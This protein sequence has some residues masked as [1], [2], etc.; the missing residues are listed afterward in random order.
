[1][2]GPTSGR[3]ARSDGN[4]DASA[5]AGGAPPSRP[6]TTR[7]QRVAWAVVG[8]TLGLVVGIWMALML[9]G[10]LADEPAA[11]T[12]DLERDLADLQGDVDALSQALAKAE[13]QMGDGEGTLASMVQLVDDV[14][15]QLDELAANVDGVLDIMD[16]QGGELEALR[17]QLEETSTE[18]DA[19]RDRLFEALLLLEYARG[20]QEGTPAPANLTL[21]ELADVLAMLSDTISQMGATQ[22][23]LSDAIAKLTSALGGGP[24]DGIALI[25]PHLSHFSSP[26]INFRCDMCHNVDLEGD[27]VVYDGALYFNGSL[28]SKDFRVQIDKDRVCSACHDWFPEGEMDP[29]YKDR[30]CVVS[31]CHDD[32]RQDMNSPFVNEAAVGEDDCLL[33]HGGQPFYPR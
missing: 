2:T 11:S 29:E 27:L 12:D 16:D 5:S 33:C 15:G 4:E 32:W 9:S 26:L 6:G 24:P 13:G 28:S 25:P 7:G 8:V 17:A 20:R 23:A 31:E 19:T 22:A 14:Q 18:L 10:T 1:M 21:D 3:V 30:T